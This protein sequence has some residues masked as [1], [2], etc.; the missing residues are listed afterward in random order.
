MPQCSI[1]KF[2]G[3]DPEPL[4]TAPVIARQGQYEFDARAR[5]QSPDRH[6]GIG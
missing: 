2:F 6:L 1:L 4:D 5:R 3:L